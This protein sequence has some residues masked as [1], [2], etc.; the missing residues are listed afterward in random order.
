MTIS[1][2]NSDE[3]NYKNQISEIIHDALVDLY[4]ANGYKSIMQT[5]TKICGKSE[6]EIITNYELFAELIE[7][8][9]GRL[10][11]S[12]ILDPIKFEINKIGEDNIK[13]EEKP[14]LKKPMRLLIA[15]DEPAILKLYETWLKFENRTVITAEDGQKCIDIYKKEFEHHQSKNYFDV[16]ILDQKMPKKTGLQAASEILKI[17][18]SQRIIF[19]SGYIE[20]TLMESLTQLNRVIEVIEKPFSLEAL[21][22]MI[23]QTKVHE[24]LQK[25]NINQQEKEVSE[26]VIEVMAILKNQ[27]Y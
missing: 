15:D 10:G 12:K 7:G 23:N 8:I 26:K 2:T 22:N 13:Q 18:P 1:R 24:K 14:S 5:M 25:I 3:S 4:G 9:F 16:V 20:K 6:K 17:N 27:N 11:D 19:A 21:D